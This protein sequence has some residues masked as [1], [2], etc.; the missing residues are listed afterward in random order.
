MTAH[1]TAWFGDRAV[2]IDV[3]S[4]LD[5]ESVATTV[6]RAL[7]ETV[8][9]RGISSLMVE[10]L[11]PDV[12]LEADVR[13]VLASI[14]ESPKASQAPETS[15]APPA[16]AIITIDVAYD[17][18]DLFPT[19]TFFGISDT[20]LVQA[21]T[22]Q[23]WRVALMGFA[24]GFGYLEPIEA[25]VLP[26][27]SLPRRTTPRATVPA[28]SVALAA[29]MSA[30]YPTSSPGGWHLIGTSRRTLFDPDNDSRPT[31][32]VPGATV[33]FAAIDH[34]PTP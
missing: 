11:S 29:G 12:N 9:R 4:P 21:H 15:K 26:W 5:R 25:P 14:D 20:E 24:P 32:L 10:V 3:A 13:H 17:G 33:R 7:P 1:E 31:L 16:D 30:I 23:R 28:G 19:A 22:S 34:K 2:V 6:M 18:P 27:S 8:V